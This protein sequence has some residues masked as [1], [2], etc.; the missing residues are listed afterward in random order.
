MPIFESWLQICSKAD[1]TA[2]NL[3]ASADPQQVAPALVGSRV[4][5]LLQAWLDPDFDPIEAG[6]LHIRLIIIGLS[7]S[8][9]SEVP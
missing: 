5:L 7:F 2:K 1:M 3:K 8:C 4:A 9:P 6:R